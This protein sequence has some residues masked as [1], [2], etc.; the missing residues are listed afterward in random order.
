MFPGLSRDA[1]QP[2]V[3]S[4]ELKAI[5]LLVGRA[6]LPRLPDVECSRRRHRKPPSRSFSPL[7]VVKTAAETDVALRDD[8]VG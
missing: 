3:V 1:R 6:D 5:P 7:R 2:S 8:D 4:L